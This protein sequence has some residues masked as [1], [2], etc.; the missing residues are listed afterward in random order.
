MDEREQKSQ[1]IHRENV[2]AYRH[3]Q[4]KLLNHT[5]EEGE[6]VTSPILK[7]H[8][9]R[10]YSLSQT[11]E[12]G[13][14]RSGLPPPRR[15]EMNF[16]WSRR[17]YGW[18]RIRKMTIIRTSVSL[19]SWHS[20]LSSWSFGKGSHNDGGLLNW[21]DLRKNR[22]KNEYNVLDMQENCK[23]VIRLGEPRTVITNHH[24]KGENIG[25][26]LIT[27]GGVHWKRSL[28]Y[29]IAEVMRSIFVLDTLS[30]SSI[31]KMSAT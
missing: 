5:V 12:R 30:V 28:L 25:I 21:S 27:L 8:V 20:M 3:S 7:K 13:S 10:F 29:Y 15:T 14:Q 16:M 17:R 19:A 22:W 31:Q 24:I 26:K 23:T 1:D 2:L 9:D 4:S 6:G 11:Q 18:L